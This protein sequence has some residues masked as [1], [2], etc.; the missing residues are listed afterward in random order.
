MA[1]FRLAMLLLGVDKTDEATDEFKLT[2]Q[3][4]PNFSPAYNEMGL[5]ALEDGEYGKALEFLK[6]AVELDSTYSTAYYN[7]GG[8]LANIGEY[9]EAAKAYRNYLTNADTPADSSEVNALIDIL[10]SAGEK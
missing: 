7:M 3:H 4:N 10:L 9:R 5:M 8:V 2:I 6:N 1:H